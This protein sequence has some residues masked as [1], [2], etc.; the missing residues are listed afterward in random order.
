VS[1]EA[2][3]ALQDGHCFEDFVASCL[4]HA[5][6]LQNMVINV[7]HMRGEIVEQEVDIVLNHAGRIWVI[8]CKLPG[9]QPITT[10]IRNADNTRRH[11]GGLNARYIMVRPNRVCEDFEKEVAAAHRIDIVDAEQWRQF[12]ARMAEL[13]GVKPLPQRAQGLDEQLARWQENRPLRGLVEPRTEASFEFYTYTKRSLIL[14]DQWVEELFRVGGRSWVAAQLY[15]AS[16]VAADLNRLERTSFEAALADVAKRWG[17]R[18]YTFFMSKQGV[19][20]V[21]LLKGGNLAEMAA[22]LEELV[23]PAE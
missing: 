21:Y 14:F 3:G 1:P 7:K 16:L 6:G 2:H 18:F 10:Q 17:G 4:A 9:N 23:S 19:R 12:C 5:L 11:I 22:E 8:D 13:L 15:G 20:I